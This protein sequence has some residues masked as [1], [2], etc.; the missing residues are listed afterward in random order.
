[1]SGV[2]VAVL[3]DTEATHSFISEWIATSF[4]CNLE[5]SRATFN[6]VNLMVNSV[7]RVVHPAPL[8]VRSWFNTW[9]ST[10]AQL[11]DHAMILGKYFLKYVNAFP[12]SHEGFLMFLYESKMP[13]VPIMTKRKLRWRPRSV[14]IKLIEEVCERADIPCEMVQKQYVT[15]TMVSLSVMNQE[16]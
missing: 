4:N 11:D 5:K 9:D 6:M 14:S 7:T 12:V 16:E 3:V 10:A 1:M 2:K 13:S 8:R 15:P